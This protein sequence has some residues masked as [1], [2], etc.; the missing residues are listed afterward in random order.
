VQ[1]FLKQRGIESVESGEPSESGE[2]DEL[3]GFFSAN[4]FETKTE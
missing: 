1:I 2:T 4:V 3:K